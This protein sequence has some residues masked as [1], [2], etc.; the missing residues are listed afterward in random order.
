MICAD[1]VKDAVMAEVKL[2]T[3]GARGLD[4]IN[5]EEYIRQIDDSQS[6]PGRLLEM[7]SSHPVTHKRVLAFKLFSQCETLYKWRPEWKNPDMAV[8]PKKL[9]DKECREFIS[10]FRNVK[11]SERRGKNEQ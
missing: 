1:D 2:R 7:F 3:G 11:P 6:T 8:M 10:V 4:D 9:I 5:I